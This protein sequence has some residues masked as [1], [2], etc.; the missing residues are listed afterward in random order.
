MNAGLC[1]ERRVSHKAGF[2]VQHWIRITTVKMLGNDKRGRKRRGA[3]REEPVKEK[4]ERDTNEN[5]DKRQDEWCDCFKF[6]K[7][8]REEDMPLVHHFTDSCI[9]THNKFLPEQALNQVAVATCFQKIGMKGNSPIEK[10]RWAMLWTDCGNM[11]AGR[12]SH[13]RSAVIE[14]I[15]NLFHGETNPHKQT[16]EQH[17][18]IFN[19]CFF[20]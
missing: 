12:M 6:P 20:Q 11:I 2:P 18:L 3:N 9:M 14:K 7:K 1:P 5:E 10:L 4:P 17:E 16:S 15:K 13:G 19:L 8:P